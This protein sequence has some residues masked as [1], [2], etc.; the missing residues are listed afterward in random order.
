MATYTYYVNTA[1]SGGDGTTNNTSGSTAA[2]QWLRTALST[3]AGVHGA[4][5]TVIIECCGTTQ[6]TSR[7][8]VD[9][10]HALDQLIIRGNRAHAAGFYDGTLLWSANHYR[11][12]HQSAWGD[13]NILQV[14]DPN[15]TIDGLQLMHNRNSGVAIEFTS[16]CQGSVIRNCRIRSLYLNSHT[17][18]VNPASFETRNITIENNIIMG[19]GGIP[20]IYYGTNSAN[21]AGV[22][23]RINHNIILNCSTGISVYGSGGDTVDVKNNAVFDCSTDISLAGSLTGTVTSTNNCTDDGSGSNP[24]T[25]LSG[26][27]LN[28]YVDPQN[29]TA[30]SRDFEPVSGGNIDGNG[31]GSATDGNLPTT[32]LL[33]NAR[34]TTAPTIGALEIT[35]VAPQATGDFW[36]AADT[37]AF[38]AV[39]DKV[40]GG[41]FEAVAPLSAW[42]GSGL[43]ARVGQLLA[44]AGSAAAGFLG[45]VTAVGQFL[46][47]ADK[48]RASFSGVVIAAPPRVGAFQVAADAASA[49][50]AGLV[51]TTGRFV[52]RADTAA[53]A[54][55]GAVPAEG[56]FSAQAGLSRAAFAGLVPAAGSF[57][58]VQGLSAVSFLGGRVRTGSFVCQ[59]LS[60]VDFR[61]VVPSAGQFA[62]LSG[63]SSF[64]GTGERTVAATVVNADAAHQVLDGPLIDA[65]VLDSQNAYSATAVQRAG[66][67]IVQQ[68]AFT[69]ARASRAV[70][71]K[72]YVEFTH[73]GGAINSNM[74][75]GLVESA[76]SSWGTWVGNTADSFGLGAAGGYYNNGSPADGTFAAITAGQTLMV[77]FDADAR[78]L[79]FG[80]ADTGVWFGSG[81]PG[82]GANPV[83]TPA[84]GT[85]YFAATTGDSGQ[86]WTFNAGQRPFVHGPPS[87]FRGLGDF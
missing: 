25:P 36:A 20:G 64:A 78:Q 65:A 37:S 87:G 52:V 72:R 50:L 70:V 2:F 59:T 49:A 82:A 75:V 69:S 23:A 38:S 77:A 51:T 79:W 33:G 14:K 80:L 11:L 60:A 35:A 85:Y 46:S 29:A 1:S 86:D 8:V 16:N 71:G 30:A 58:A 81:D 41:P 68:T 15:V 9:G 48:A 4:G 53:A 84:A 10:F 31:Q 67:A 56:G 73:S 12:N 28:E 19:P 3:L 26:S 32:D 40:I 61:G 55:S 47:A 21:G 76:F 74:L 63:A 42:A 5:D 6:E 13:F 39:G 44:S 27:W 54:F 45:G 7:A 66:R 24:Q 83:Y 18:W 17:I 57:D 43:V 62:A 34:S 22:H